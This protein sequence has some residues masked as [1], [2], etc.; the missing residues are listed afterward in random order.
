MFFPLSAEQ[1]ISKSEDNPVAFFPLG[2]TSYSSP[3]FIILFNEIEN[4]I[5]T[6]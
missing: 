4:W 1:T 5:P 2:V 3:K 6:L